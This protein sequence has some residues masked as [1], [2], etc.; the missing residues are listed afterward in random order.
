MVSS[1]FY[2][3]G[4]L[5]KQQA[6]HASKT[7]A[8]SSPKLK[9]LAQAVNYFLNGQYSKILDAEEEDDDDEDEDVPE[10]ASERWEIIES[11]HWGEEEDEVSQWLDENFAQ[12]QRSQ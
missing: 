10:E 9:K 12:L 2:F 1:S 8:A 7:A 4:G 5:K 3:G 11:L 6:E